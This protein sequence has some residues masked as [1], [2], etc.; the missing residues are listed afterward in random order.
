MISIEAGFSSTITTLN[1]GEGGTLF[2]LEL[3]RVLS[4]VAEK[5]VMDGKVS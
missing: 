2:H 4:T 3:Y 5:N 1:Q